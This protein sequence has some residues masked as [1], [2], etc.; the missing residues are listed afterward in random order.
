VLAAAAAARADRRAPG[1][2]QPADAAP[3]AKPR[4]AASPAPR[5]SATG[6]GGNGRHRP[7]SGSRRHR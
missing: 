3:S 6:R 2:R 1:A 5:P 4:P 7:P